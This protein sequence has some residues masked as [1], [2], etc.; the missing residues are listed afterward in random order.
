MCMSFAALA[1]CRLDADSWIK[2]RCG[3]SRRPSAGAGGLSGRPYLI[4][5][6]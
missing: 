1:G 3:G 4:V 6:G 2:I 5:D